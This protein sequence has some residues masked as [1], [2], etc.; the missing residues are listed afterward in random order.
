MPLY[1]QTVRKMWLFHACVVVAIAGGGWATRS[2]HAAEVEIP[3]FEAMDLLDKARHDCA[4]EKIDSAELYLSRF[5]EALG[6]GELPDDVQIA[7]LDMRLKIAAARAMMAFQQRQPRTGVEDGSSEEFAKVWSVVDD[8][9]NEFLAYCR[10]K[11]AQ[12]EEQQNFGEVVA[13]SAEEQSLRRHRAL[14]LEYATAYPKAL[15]E[16]DEALAIY[17][18]CLPHLAEKITVLYPTPH[19]EERKEVTRAEEY[20]LATPKAIAQKRM[21]VLRIWQSAAPNDAAIKEALTAT[22]KKF[23]QDFPSSP[24]ALSIS[25]D[26]AEIREM[27]TATQKKFLQDFPGSPE[28]LAISSD[29]AEI[30]ETLTLMREKLLK[31]F[32]GHPDAYGIAWKVFEA[33]GT[34][35]ADALKTI[36]DATPDKTT[37]QYAS[38]LISHAN[39]LSV[40]EHR[41]DEALAEYEAALALPACP[42]DR[43]TEIHSQ[44]ADMHFFSKRYDKAREYI[45]EAKRH[46]S[47]LDAIAFNLD[48]RLEAIDIFESTARATRSRPMT[49]SPSDS[50]TVLRQWLF[51][52]NT[53]AVLLLGGYY[54]WRRFSTHRSGQS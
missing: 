8:R 37:M 28:A 14:I 12:A 23:L 22:Q 5:R 10:R 9:T 35:S 51:W 50:T 20:N 4:A 33:R 7:V 2:A 18:R 34:L 27:L 53:L 42:Q 41:Y 52:L 13:V 38:D 26:D 40:N 32:P 49:V 44:M 39:R 43:L 1:S 11:K 30:K 3:S 6:K 29:D 25:S 24:E 45:L 15:L 16:L 19:G 54:T 36:L 17:T 48:S 21:Y 46:A 47:P 31:D